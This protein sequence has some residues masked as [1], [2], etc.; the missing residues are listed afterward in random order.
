MYSRYAG[1]VR[2]GRRTQRLAVALV[3]AVAVGALLA[4][5]AERPQFGT[6][7]NRGAVTEFA[8]PVPIETFSGSTADGGVFDSAAYRGRVLVVNLW[9][10]NCPPCRREAP[11]LV[12]L[13]RQFRDD[14]VQFVGINTRDT[15]GTAQAFEATFG[16]PYPSILD[17][18]DGAAQLALSRSSAVAPNATPTTLVLDGQGRVTA[19]IL[20]EIPDRSILESLIETAL[21]GEQAP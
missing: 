12:A 11:D 2:P 6:T 20:G 3:V 13:S 21:E 18:Q 4:G 19:R 9:Y 14:G 8:N 5:C 15:A 10:A 17:A 16:I 1:P 7:S